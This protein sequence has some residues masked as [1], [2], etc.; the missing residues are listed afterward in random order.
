MLQYAGI[1]NGE[2]Q[3]RV[4]TVSVSSGYGRGIAHMRADWCFLAHVLN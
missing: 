4:T 1:Y 3:L 2:F